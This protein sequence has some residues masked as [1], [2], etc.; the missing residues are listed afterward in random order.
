MAD[1][2]SHLPPVLYENVT[3]AVT[4]R[5][6][7]PHHARPGEVLID[8]SWRIRPDASCGPLTQ[9]AAEDLRQTLLKVFNIRPRKEARGIDMTV[10]GTSTDKEESSRLSV[11]PGGIQI[12]AASDIAAM[13]ALFDLRWRMLNRQ[14]PA[15]KQGVETIAPAWS[16]RIMSP[17]WHRPI[18]RP[19]DYVALPDAYLL[20][21]AR[22]GYNATYLF[23]DWLDYMSPKAGGKLARKGWRQRIESLRAAVHHLGRFGIQLL[24][25]VNTM[26]MRRDHPFFMAD[27]AMRGAQTWRDGVH[28][29][30]SSNPKTL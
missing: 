27:P 30:C 29:L 10:S 24:M 1:F 21:V 9:L 16:M 8:G 7:G 4:H 6:P 14:A 23:G 22:Y 5:F 18:D 15:L 11:T 17:V 12:D 13:R 26:A 20:N 25:H 3:R 19:E 2:A 28:C